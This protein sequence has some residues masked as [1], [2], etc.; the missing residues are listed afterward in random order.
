M[1]LPKL[2][3]KLGLRSMVAR[4]DPMMEKKQLS[5]EQED[6][7]NKWHELHINA[8]LRF[9]KSLEQRQNP[10]L[11]YLSYAVVKKAGESGDSL[12]LGGGAVKSGKSGKR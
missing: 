12:G 2:A 10:H 3:G 7:N 1:T 4:G 11:T 9:R 5:P 6:T 8:Y